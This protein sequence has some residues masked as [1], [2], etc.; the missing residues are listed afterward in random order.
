MKEIKAIIRPA[1]LDRLRKALRATPGFPGMSVSRVEGCGAHSSAPAGSI[2]DELTDFSAK[3]R[4]EIVA[5]DEIADALVDCIVNIAC[6][7]QTGDG[8]VW[9]TEVHRAVFINKT[10]AGSKD[11]ALD[12]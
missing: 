1:K 3:L 2:R 8:L 12:W 10:V 4:I 9:S 11:D 7:G 6:T 5:P